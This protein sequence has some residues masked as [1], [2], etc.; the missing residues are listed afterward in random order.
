MSEV[1]GAEAPG[2][3]FA[4]STNSKTKVKVTFDI[5]DRTTYTL[6]DKYVTIR[7]YRGDEDIKGWMLIGN[8]QY[9][10]LGSN[11]E[12][13]ANALINLGVQG[14]G[15]HDHSGGRRKRQSRRQTRRQSRRR[16]RSRSRRV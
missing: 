13:V 2:A 6:D 1:L 8:G 10:F 14:K 9:V 11:T 15:R 5:S 4:T 7:D 16:S 3:Q 12:E